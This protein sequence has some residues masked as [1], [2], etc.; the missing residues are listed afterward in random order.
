MTGWQS[1]ETAPKDGTWFLAARKGEGFEEYEIGAYDP[2]LFDR[3]EEVEGGLYRKLQERGYEWRG[4]NNMHR[5][6][7]WMPLPPPPSD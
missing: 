5:M 7:H 6:T 2:L 1:I 4:F 3:Y